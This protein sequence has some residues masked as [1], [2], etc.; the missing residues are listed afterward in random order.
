ME[1]SA[2]HAMLLEPMK[3]RLA[4]HSLYDK[5]LKSSK[6]PK[7]IAKERATGYVVKMLDESEARDIRERDFYLKLFS[8]DET[9]DDVIQ[10]RTLVAPF[11]GILKLNNPERTALRFEDVSLTNSMDIK[12]GN[13]T[14]DPQ[15]SEE[16]RL[17][18][19]SKK[20]FKDQTF[21]I[22]GFRVE[23]ETGE[24]ISKS[25]EEMAEYVD[26]VHI[27]ELFLQK[28]QKRRNA[29]V[30]ELQVIEDF[31][32]KQKSFL[33]ISSSLLLSYSQDRVSVKMIDF[34]H[35]FPAQQVDENYLAAVSDLIETIS[36]LC[37]GGDQANHP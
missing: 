26:S 34:A 3:T 8:E 7:G 16:K 27:L 1:V 30:K 11:K 12:M 21:R 37:L 4:G 17:H 14:W 22:L 5:R 33:I 28:N 19:I 18:E 9:S 15:S 35:T 36:Q 31:F 13:I 24:T 6:I 10:L 29:F 20:S 2:E 25:K 32:R 23:C